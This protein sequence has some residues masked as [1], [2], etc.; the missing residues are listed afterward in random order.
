MI[1]SVWAPSAQAVELVT[2]RDGGIE[3]TRDA[4]G[5]RADGGGRMSRPRVAPRRLPVLDRRPG[6]ASRIRVRAGSRAACMAPRTCSMP[7][8]G[9]R[10]G[11]RGFSPKPMR[12]AIIYELHVGTFTPAGTYAAAARAA[13]S[14]GGSRRDACRAHAA[15]DVSGPAR[16]GLRRRRSV[17]AACRRTAL[18]PTSIRFIEACHER[19]LGRAARCGLQPSGSRRQL[20]R[21]LRPVF[22]RPRED[23]VGRSRQLRRRRGATRCAGSS[24]TTRSC[25]CGTTGS[26]ACGS[27][28]CTQSSASRRCTSWKSWR[29]RCGGLARSSIASL[30]LIAESDLNDPR[31][32]HP[33]ARGG[34]GLD[35]HWSDDFHHAIHRYFTGES[36]GY[37]AD[38]DGLAD[39]A[40][41]LAR[42][43]CLP[44][45]VLGDS[46]SAAT[47]GRPRGVGRRTSWWCARR[48]T[49]RSATA[50]AA[51][52]CP[53]CSTYRGSRRSRP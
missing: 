50:R 12:E 5:A 52:G 30:V 35:A 38:F 1:F 3:R 8:R 19:G 7:R 18:P 40:T 21:R 6:S 25:G 36:A 17:R 41:A 24:S 39:L 46:G 34:Y 33:V 23:A 20:P 32:V 27:T 43:L 29:R 11:A 53:C 13:R 28:R 16:L 49:I 47:G 9:R 48:I 44:G 45:S 15:R 14:P 2:A 51:S 4:P 26:T 22:H 37:Y 31:L 42:R 10:T